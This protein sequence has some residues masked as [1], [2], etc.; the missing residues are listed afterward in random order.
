MLS[1]QEIMDLW[2][3]EYGDIPCPFISCDDV[4]VN[5][6]KKHVMWFA[7]VPNLSVYAVEAYCTDEPEIMWVPQLNASYITETV[8]FTHQEQA[9]AV[10]YGL[11]VQEF[12][13][14][15][16]AKE[17]LDKMMKPQ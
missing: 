6:T 1:R 2:C 5:T 4:V 16:D 13:R 3:E 10:I 11:L 14:L 9:A 15:V 8:L 12:K 17:R 7:D